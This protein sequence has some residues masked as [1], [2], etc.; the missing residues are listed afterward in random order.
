[1]SFILIEV[2]YYSSL[3][4]NCY[5]INII[6]PYIIN[7]INTFA[8]AP[9]SHNPMV[10]CG[11]HADRSRCWDQ[12]KAIKPFHQEQFWYFGD[13]NQQLGKQQK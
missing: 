3:I 10:G 13:I 5:L 9:S 6:S 4:L 12:I 7:E 8:F 2:K 11:P 1:M